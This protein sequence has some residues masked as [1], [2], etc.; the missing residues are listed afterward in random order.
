MIAGEKD[1]MKVVQEIFVSMLGRLPDQRELEAGLR[2]VQGGRD[3]NERLAA[4]YNKQ[5][6]D[7]AAY[8]KQLGEK[9][10]AWED[11]LKQ[12]LAWTVLDPD[13]ALPSGGA[14]LTKE[15]AAPCQ[16]QESTPETYTIKAKSQLKGITAVRLEV[17]PDPRLPSN[18]PGRAERQLCNERSAAVG[19]ADRFQG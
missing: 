7:L 9:Q 6:A 17:L 14:V 15:S 18:G 1:D 16:R 5:V 12:S 4:D 10:A 19:R 2:A 13:G 11:E 8:E 3:E